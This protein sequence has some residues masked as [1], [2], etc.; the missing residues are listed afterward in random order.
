MQED[1]TKQPLDERK[2]NA[3]LRYI[4]VL[5]AVAF[6]LV[7]F[8]LLRQMRDSRQTISELNQSSASAL[9]KAEQLQDQNRTLLEENSNLEEQI[10]DLQKQ[11]Q[12]QNEAAALAEEEAKAQQEALLQEMEAVRTDTKLAHTEIEHVKTAYEQLLLAMELVTPG[13]QEGNVA[14]SKA[15][16]NLQSLQQYLGETALRIYH[17][18]LEEGE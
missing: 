3:L 4:A 14:A 5:F 2:K 18:L 9:T 8:S 12:E 15:L 6:L 10:A 13:A 7:L 16:E 17:N 1:T 11:L